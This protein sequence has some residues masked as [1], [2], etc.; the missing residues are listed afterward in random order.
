MP[1]ILPQIGWQISVCWKRC[2]IRHMKRAMMTVKTDLTRRG[3]SGKIKSRYHHR[4]PTEAAEGTSG[5][6]E[7]RKFL[8]K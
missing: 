2:W 6:A 3:I 4:S 5:A 1:R 7:G 8:I